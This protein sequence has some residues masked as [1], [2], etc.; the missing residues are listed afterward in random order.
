MCSNSNSDISRKSLSANSHP[1]A[2]IVDRG[3][4]LCLNE[5]LSRGDLISELSLRIKQKRINNKRRTRQKTFK[6]R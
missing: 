1:L 3:T 5:R 4:A 6:V 2:N